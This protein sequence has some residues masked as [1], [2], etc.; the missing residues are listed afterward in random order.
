MTRGPHPQG[1]DGMNSRTLTS[2]SRNLLTNAGGETT[3]SL[4]RT[5]AA[6]C[7][8]RVSRVL[9]AAAAL[10][11]AGL[12]FAAWI[13]PL[14]AAAHAGLAANRPSGVITI[15]ADFGGLFVAL[16]M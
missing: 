2:K 8:N 9:V 6:M 5:R 4:A 1:N 10:L 3:A 15:G 13:S 14:D 16:A 12:G 11:F 7:L